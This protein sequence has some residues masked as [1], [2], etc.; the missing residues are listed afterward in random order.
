MPVFASASQATRRTVEIAALVIASVDNLNNN[1]GA[2][3][4]LLQ[5]AHEVLDAQDRAIASIG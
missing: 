2:S 3:Q 4:R 1:I 5:Q